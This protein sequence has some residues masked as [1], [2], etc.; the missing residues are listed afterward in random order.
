MIIIKKIGLILLLLILMG[1]LAFF[2]LS[3]RDNP[4]KISYGVSFSKFHSDELQLP[5]KE[6]YKSLLDD[7][8]VRRFRLS[9]HW[10]MVEGDRGK[11]SFDELDYQMAEA[12]KRNAKVVLAVGRRLPGWPECHDPEWVK[13]VSI[14]ERE[15][16]LLLYIEAVVNRY[17]GYENLAYWQVENE[18]FLSVFAK[19][20][21]GDLDTGFLKKEIALVK[22]LDPDTKVLVTDSGNLGL[23]YNAW[24]NGDAFGTSIYLY[25]WNPTLGQVRTVYSPAVY[26]A[27]TNL[28]ELLFHKKES[29]LIELSLEPW[30]LEP[31]VDAPIEGQVE[32]MDIGKFN[33]V[34]SF[35][36]KTGFEQQYL[37]GA[38]WWYWMKSK[39]HDEYWNSA[40]E[41]FKKD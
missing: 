28:M 3:R 31:I 14:L 7:L 1:L 29:L 37:W 19:E 10:P 18:P 25:L 33:E 17:K 38:E 20:N 13:N 8:G 4:A 24:I 6:V 26:K 16:S 30:L 36:K 27:K 2:L 12:N 23:W 35:A 5:W 9:A 22:K 15:Q 41:L 39:G 21:C 34:V 40:K 32:R 11:Y